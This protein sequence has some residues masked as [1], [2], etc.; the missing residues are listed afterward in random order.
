MT[1]NSGLIS[2]RT[3]F[4]LQSNVSF[5][6]Q[7]RSRACMGRCGTKPNKLAQRNCLYSQRMQEKLQHQTFTQLGLES[8]CTLDLHRRRLDPPVL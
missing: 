6:K 2:F 7:L 1:C 3:T 5:S 4:V 8:L